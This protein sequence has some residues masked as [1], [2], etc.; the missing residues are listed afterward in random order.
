MAWPA[1]PKDPGA[2]KEFVRLSILKTIVEQKL[3]ILKKTT[4]TVPTAASVEILLDKIE[5]QAEN[6]AVDLQ[7]D[8]YIEYNSVLDDGFVNSCKHVIEILLSDIYNTDDDTRE[9]IY[10]VRQYAA[11]KHLNQPADNEKVQHIH[12]DGGVANQPAL[13]PFSPPTFAPNSLDQVIDKFQSHHYSS[14]D[15]SSDAEEAY[16]AKFWVKFNL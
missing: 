15:S 11:T 4:V 5:E 2:A 10:E 3:E 14:S 8:L 7:E 9:K 1:A 16:W 6:L 13:N 12:P